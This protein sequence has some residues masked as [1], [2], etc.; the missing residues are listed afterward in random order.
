MVAFL[1]MLFLA[2]FYTFWYVLFHVNFHFDYIR[3]MNWSYTSVFDGKNI[4][5]YFIIPKIIKVLFVS[6]GIFVSVCRFFSWASLLWISP[7]WRMV[8]LCT[9]N[10]IYFYL[11]LSF[12]NGIS[13]SPFPEF[14]HS[15]CHQHHNLQ[16]QCHMSCQIHFVDFWRFHHFFTGR[17]HLLV[18]LQWLFWWVCTCKI[19]MQVWLNMSHSIE[20]L[21]VVPWTS[22]N[23]GYVPCIC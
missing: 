14:H 7:P 2:L 23:Y 3:F 10:D 16:L 21:V 12:L 15:P 13:E 11:L 6:G 20:I 5:K 22:I 1:L 18:P 19:D 4:T 9:W 8:F 17:C